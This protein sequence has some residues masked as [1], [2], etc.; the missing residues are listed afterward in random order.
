[1]TSA[2]IDVAIVGAGPVGTLLAA[3]LARLGVAA[4]VIEQRAEAGGG[5]RAIGIHAT[6]LAAMEASGATDRLLADALR[7]RVG[8]ARRR[9]RTLGEV[10]FD[11]LHARHPFVATL[12][13]SATE[14]ALAGA[15]AAWGAPPPRRGAAVTSVRSRGG[16]D[17][18]AAG[19]VEVTLDAGSRLP[20]ASSS[21]R[22]GCARARCCPLSAARPACG[23]RPI[24]I[25]TS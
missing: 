6:A 5:S 10:R 8:E 3:E 20:P 24:R 1:M 21:S 11:R 4:A 14:A 9:G 19:A 22:A 18:G 23:G 12:P 25:A 2:V 16:A 13:Q 17:G 15:A 7:V